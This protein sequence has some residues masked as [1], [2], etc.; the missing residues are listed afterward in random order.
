M[1]QLPLQKGYEGLRSLRPVD[2][3][4]LMQAGVDAV[5]FNLSKDYELYWA[6]YGWDCDSIL[7]LNPE[8][9]IPSKGGVIRGA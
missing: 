1:E 8:I 5:E 2:F 7:I 9:I 4:A 3:E 6:L